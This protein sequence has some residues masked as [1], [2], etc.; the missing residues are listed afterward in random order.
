VTH[1]DYRY[2]SVRLQEG[3]AIVFNLT[4]RHLTFAMKLSFSLKQI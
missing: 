4:F 3:V 1:D 2:T